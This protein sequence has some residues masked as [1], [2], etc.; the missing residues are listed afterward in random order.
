MGKPETAGSRGGWE[1]ET[2]PA[3]RLRLAFE[4]FEVG[5]EVYREKVRR[6][7]PGISETELDRRVGEWLMT[8]PGAELG[9]CP[10]RAVPIAR[11][12]RR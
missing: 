4:L 3:D 12:E 1:R 8:R 5:V 7:V 2:G 6:D 10:G 11:R 9:D